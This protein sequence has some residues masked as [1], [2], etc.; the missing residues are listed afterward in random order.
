[1]VCV[2]NI[3]DLLSEANRSNFTLLK[4]IIHQNEYDFTV[5]I[6]DTLNGINYTGR[7]KKTFIHEHKWT[8]SDGSFI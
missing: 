1:M 8:F 6:L 4:Q 2:Y 5:F 7:W 3:R